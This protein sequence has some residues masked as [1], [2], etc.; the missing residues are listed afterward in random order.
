METLKIDITLLR[1][2]DV[3]YPEIEDSIKNILVMFK[4]SLT[5]VECDL[6]DNG[7]N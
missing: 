7:A 3:K 5:D 1:L 6:Y 4:S 2:D